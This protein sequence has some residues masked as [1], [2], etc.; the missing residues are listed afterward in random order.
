M[1]TG[2]VDSCRPWTG[3]RDNTHDTGLVLHPA[4][5]MIHLP[6]RRDLET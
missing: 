3:P 4:T 6:R 2:G 1:D 5:R